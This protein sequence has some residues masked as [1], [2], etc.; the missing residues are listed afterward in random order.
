MKITSGQKKI[1]VALNPVNTNNLVPTVFNYPNFANSGNFN[2]VN[3]ILYTSGSTTWGLTETAG[4]T[5]K[6]DGLIRGLANGRIGDGFSQSGPSYN[7]LM[8]N[9]DGPND[10][11]LA[12]SYNSTCLFMIRPDIDSTSSNN[13]TGANG[14]LVNQ[15]TINVQRAFAKIKLNISIPY[16]TRTP[17][18]YGDSFSDVYYEAGDAYYKGRFQPWKVADG[19]SIAGP[20]WTIGNIPKATFPFQSYSAGYIIDPYYGMTDDK[21]GNF[22]KWVSHYDNTR[23]FPNNIPSYPYAGL[24]VDAVKNVMRNS[25]NC[26]NLQGSFYTIENARMYPVT[27][28]HGTYLIMG[29]RYNPE[30]I[31]ESIT[32]SPVPGNAPTLN[33]STSYGYTI[34]DTD[35]MYY[36][37]ADGVFILNSKAL[38]GYYAWSKQL[39]IN[40]PADG[41]GFT[42]LTTGPV[43]QAL[44]NKHI[45][46]Y[47]GGQCF[48]R[49]FIGDLNATNEERRTIRRNH[50]Y[51]VQIM[52]IHGPGIDNAN[53]ILLA[54]QPV[55]E[56]NSYV[57]AKIH[58]LNWHQVDQL[59]GWDSN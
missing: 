56:L 27:H 41:S 59:Q 36:I 50:I 30:Y 48:Y 47:V 19:G 38:L 15:F 6:A 17:G 10:D 32:R 39:E 9:W 4:I 20:I 16:T 44:A 33:Y 37:V 13:Y 31:V 7:M 5:T 52:K 49:A 42:T 40:A 14:D 3:N 53:S 22:P 8:T 35:T 2:T 28:D 11:N 29:G 12:Q 45:M 54:P 55:H 43:N 26:T 51:V 1:F 24:T 34:A 23:V 57:S 25:L 18:N 21:I 46:A 58:V